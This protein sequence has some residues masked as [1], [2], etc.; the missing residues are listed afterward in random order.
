MDAMRRSCR[1]S[2]LE[3]IP[4]TDIRDRMNMK[5]DIIERIEKREAWYGH[6]TRMPENR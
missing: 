1:V 3:H 6:L 5:D 2:R 4:N